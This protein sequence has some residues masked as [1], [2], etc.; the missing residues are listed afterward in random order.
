M[1]KKLVI[2]GGSGFIGTN[3]LI[4]LSKSNNF[5][6]H[7]TYF[8]K[9]FFFKVPNVKYHKIDLSN[10]NNLLKL[11]KILK[12][13]DSVFMLAAISSG[14]KI[15]ENNPLSLFTPNIRFNLNIV[16]LCY[17]LK[18]NKFIFISSN[19]VYPVSNKSMREEDVDFSLFEKYYVVGWMKLFT[20]IIC[21]VYSTKVKDSKLKILVVRPSNLFG[22]YDKYNRTKSKV[23]AS[24][25]RKFY[26]KKQFIE[27]WGDG[28][29]I[30]DFLYVED[31]CDAL[32]H[33]YKKFK[34]FE[35]INISSGS[36]IKLI[37]IID[38][39]SKLFS[40]RKN[41][42]IF[43]KNMPTMIP[44]RKMSNHKLEKKYNYKIRSNLKA[45]LIKT[46]S[47]YKENKKIYDNY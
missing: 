23:I 33:V 44:L 27:I 8:K 42:L 34:G 25:I 21:N 19:T 9:K 4:K 47:W 28:K 20:E 30:K 35:T 7:A 14:A 16:D 22:P 2:L 1:Q 12:H 43:N 18:V 45:S 29:D 11:K 13:S 38:I 46:I 3:L 15:M 26:E 10:N 17:Q 32:L 39:L 36:S 41:E 24:L 5:E 6:L 40:I 31:F 37:K